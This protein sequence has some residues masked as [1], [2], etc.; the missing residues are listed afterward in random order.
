LIG[1]YRLV[2]PLGAGGMGEVYKGVH[3]HLGRVIAV[4]ILSPDLADGPALQRFYAEAD[5]QASLRQPGVAEYL[6]F[7]E[8]QGRP[9]ILMEFVDGETL[10]AMIRRR[11][12]L[13]PGEAAAI[14]RDIAAVTGRFHALGVVHRDLKTSNVK[15]NSAGQVKIL[16]FGIA[17]H[18]RSD[19]MTRA[20]AVIGTTEILA[21][22]QVKGE[23]AGLGTDVWQI[24]V[25]FFELLTGRMPFEASST[26]E[27]YARIL[28]A[29][30]PPLEQ[31]QPAAPPALRKI[32]TRC[33]EKDA[34]KRYASGSTLYDALSNWESGTRTQIDRRRVALVAGG[35]VAALLLITGGILA[36]R[37]TGGDGPDKTTESGKT[38]ET[39]PLTDARAITVDAADG[40]AQVFRDGKLV[41]TTPFLVRAQAGESV[42][43]VLKRQG[44]DDRAVQ[45]DATER[46]TYTFTLDAK[47]P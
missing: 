23:E 40:V 7:Y 37:H 33:L 25:M 27:L 30:Y 9:C 43:L 42:N 44:Y 11:G 35:A 47:E 46:K 8:Y 22:E 38:T 1:E 4:K 5:I 3:I 6:G 14:V 29:Q 20:G 16:D 21:P 19:R 17:R 15:I 41:G 24:G 36:V 31:L 2:E 39:P 10:A 32:V 34:A 45:F 12:P 18:Q 13:P 26:A 28:A